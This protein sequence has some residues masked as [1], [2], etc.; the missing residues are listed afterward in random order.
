MN[1]AEIIS[2][3]NLRGLIF[4]FFQQLKG[5]WPLTYCDKLMKS[6]SHSISEGLI[7]KFLTIIEVLYLMDLK[8]C[9][10]LLKLLPHSISVGLV[11]KNFPGK[12]FKSHT[13]TKF[14]RL[15]LHTKI[16]YRYVSYMR[17]PHI[18]NLPWAPWTLL[19]GLLLPAATSV[20]RGSQTQ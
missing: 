6:P 15:S 5:K 12:A 20:W 11:H 17:G 7:L 16:I 2:K 10:I 18:Y 1:T 8:C 9:D 13:S 14:T 19:A 4:K 3:F